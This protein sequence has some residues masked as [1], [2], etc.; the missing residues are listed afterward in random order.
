MDEKD[1][2]RFLKSNFE[3]NYGQGI[4][5]DTSAVKIGDS[6]QLITNDILVENIHFKL[7][8]FNLS[9]IAHKSLAVN[10]SDIASMGG[11]PE[12]YYL[13]LGF[14]DYLEKNSLFEFFNS[15]KEGNK[16]WKI[17]LA[18][19]DFSRSTAIFISITMIG[20]TKNPIYRDNANNTDL[21]GITGITGDS[22]IGL[23]LLERG[24]NKGFFVKKHKI[25]S[26]EVGKGLILS[27]YV[28]SMIDVSDGLLLDLDRILAASEKG[29]RIF[30]EKIPVTQKIKSICK[31]YKFSEYEMVLT[32]GEDYV[33]LFTISE[34]N[35]LKLREENIKYHIIGEINDLYESLNVEHKGK[36]L[37]IENFGYDHF[38]S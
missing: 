7:N 16:R 17:E 14:P 8:Y 4:G 13:G 15:L 11:E 23:R 31:Q 22:A 35:E 29:A 24:I 3:F 25:V 38:K 28:N 21:I 18:G 6:Y 37:Q 34:E 1:F 30:Y 27:K 12:Y 9:E 26:P 20:K 19:G 10:I 33:L 2:V 36:K 5:D 32:G